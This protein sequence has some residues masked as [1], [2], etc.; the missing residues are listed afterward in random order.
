MQLQRLTRLICVALLCGSASVQ[1]SPFQFTYTGTVSSVNNIGG[2]ATVGDAVTVNV[3]VDNG[4]TSAI[5]QN[6]A[7]TD[8]VSAVFTAGSYVA[9]FLSDWFSYGSGFTTDALGDLT[10]AEWYGTQMST[11][12]D[13]FG[14]G[15]YLSNVGASNSNGRN[16]YASSNFELSTFSGPIAVASS[17]PEPATIAL[18]GLGLAGI[19]IGKR[20][21]AKV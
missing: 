7:V 18:L 6:W 8:T 20:R 2:L 3:I 16:I 15:V 19:A 4:G 14:T 9:T 17:V 21:K 1:A 5:S 10:T 11:G 12:T 13:N